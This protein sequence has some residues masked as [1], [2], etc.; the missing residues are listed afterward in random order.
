MS[1]RSAV[2]KPSVNRRR[3]ARAA[4]VPGPPALLA[5]EPGKARGMAQFVAARALLA[6]DRQGGAERLLGLRRIGI[7]QAT[8]EFA[9]HAMNF[10]VPA[11]RAGDGRFCQ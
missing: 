2:S 7:W 11:P 10:C 6:G 1:L 5:P 8:A 3:R 4:R 9:A